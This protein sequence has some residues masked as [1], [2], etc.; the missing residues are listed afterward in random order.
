MP[1]NG[2][3]FLFFLSLNYEYHGQLCQNGFWFT[4][5]PAHT[6]EPDPA[7]Q[8]ADLITQF[9]N[10]VYLNIKALMVQEVHFR[11]IVGVTMNPHNGPIAEFIIESGT[12]NQSDEGLPSYC[13]AV[14]SLRTGVGGR[15]HLG[16][17]YFSG[18]G[19]G[20]SETSRLTASG[21]SGLQGIGGEL[22]TRFG[23]ASGTNTWNYGVWSRLNS[24]VD[25][26]RDAPNVDF[27]FQ[28][29]TQCLGRV[30]L[31]TQKHRQIG[32]GG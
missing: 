26:A 9:K 14:L 22:L 29:V 3:P 7:V 15:R 2:F 10:T 4:E 25:G 21:L 1:F 11:S 17:L 19:E 30:I 6:T 23:H 18:I 24:L 32:H 13:A 8:L 28:Y 27:G 31:G 5:N 20:F 12:G 16:R